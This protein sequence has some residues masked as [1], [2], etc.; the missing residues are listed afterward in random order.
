MWPQ[1]QGPGQPV[2]SCPDA[3]PVLPYDECFTCMI[4]P[5]GCSVQWGSERLSNFPKV[6]QLLSGTE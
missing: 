5:T 1:T 6:T 2:H 4:F 3:C